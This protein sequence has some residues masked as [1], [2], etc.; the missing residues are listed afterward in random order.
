MEN[1]ADSTSPRYLRNEVTPFLSSGKIENIHMRLCTGCSE[2]VSI[3]W[4]YLTS[5]PWRAG[6][7]AS[8]LANGTVF[9]T[10]MKETTTCNIYKITKLHGAFFSTA[11][12]RVVLEQLLRNLDVAMTDVSSGTGR[13]RETHQILHSCGHTAVFLI[14]LG[15]AWLCCHALLLFSF[16]FFPGSGRAIS[17]SEV[18]DIIEIFWFWLHCVHAHSKLS[19]RVVVQWYSPLKCQLSQIDHTQI[20]MHMPPRKHSCDY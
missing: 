12:L 10:R 13:Q 8:C 17:Y 9:I 7:T 18:D 11:M 20:V 3:Y 15:A 16:L 5:I 1:N 14:L 4:R 6:Q 19:N 2:Y